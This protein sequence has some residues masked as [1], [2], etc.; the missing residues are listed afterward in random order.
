MIDATQ[1]LSLLA[2]FLIGL[3]G[4][5]HCV[6]M[7]GGIA[8]GLGLATEGKRSWP[9][10]AGYNLGRVASYALAGA[11]VATLGYWGKSYLAAGPALRIAAGVILILM[12]LYLADV[13]RALVV[14]EKAGAGLWKI[15]QPLGTALMPVRTL[16]RALALG[17]VWGW[18]P[19]GLV[20]SA[21]AYSAASASPAYGALMMVAFGAGTAPAMLVGGLFSGA[22]KRFL[23]A[24]PVRLLMAVLMVVF[25]LWTLY[26]G[27][28]HMNHTS[29][30]QSG[31]E[32]MEHHHHH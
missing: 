8:T 25:G 24:R 13:W 12:G 2:L 5:G 17:M 28:A 23:Q 31:G 15:I 18:L 16:P 4:S 29:S 26:S 10:V 32:G 14:L 21:L 20:Y 22:M 7:C 3:A 11:L 9:L 30:P 6:G 19:C 27:V 1:P